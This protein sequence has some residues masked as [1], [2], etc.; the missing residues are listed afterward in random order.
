MIAS[1]RRGCVAKLAP[2]RDRRRERRERSGSSIR[3]SPGSCTPKWSI[4]SWANQLRTN[5]DAPIR[6]GELPPWF[7]SLASAQVSCIR[8]FFGAYYRYREPVKDRMD[9]TGA[10]WGLSGAEALLRQGSGA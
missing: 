2:E 8:C 6:D 4:H 7:R 3:P 10:R 1:R 5:D 9:L